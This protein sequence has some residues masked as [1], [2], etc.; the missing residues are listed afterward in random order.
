MTY[1]KKLMVL[2][3]FCISFLLATQVF[4]DE[5]KD[6]HP[7]V[8]CSGV[9]IK[10]DGKFLFLL[11]GKGKSHAGKWGIPGGKVE[12]G[13]LPE[14][15]S[16]RES[17]EETGLDLIGCISFIK[18]VYIKNGIDFVWHMYQTELK[19]KPAVVISKEHTTYKWSTLQEALELPLIPG[20]AQCIELVFGALQID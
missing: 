13:E 7:V 10:C 12:R 18:T 17:L 14:Q 6:F 2:P 16:I 9:F 11:T 20:E 8:E 19:E 4:V 3:F 5:P 15:A 1:I